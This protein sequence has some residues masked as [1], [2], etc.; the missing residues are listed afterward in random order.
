MLVIEGDAGVGKTYAL[1][2]CREAFDASGVEVVGCALAGRAAELL[3]EGSDIASTTVAATLHQLQVE[4][5]PYGGVLVV[6]EAGM[7]G[8]RQLAELVSLAARDEAKLV[9]VGDPFQL[10]PIEAGAPMRTLSDHIGRVEL[11]ENIRQQYDW[12]RATLQLLRDGEARAAYREY[13]RYDRIHDAHSVAERRVQVIE[14]HARL[15]AGGLDTVILARRRDE[16]AALNEL[17]H[18]RSVAEGQSPRPG[19]DRG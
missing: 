8:D 17:A 5:L 6:D 7:L 13:E 11:H 2:V 10:Q 12:E 15:E 14:D 18:A 3:E 9:V 1:E 4:R 16:V 19:A